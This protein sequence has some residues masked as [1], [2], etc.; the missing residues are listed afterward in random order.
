MDNV[1]FCAGYFGKRQG[2]DQV[3]N[4]PIVNFPRIVDLISVCIFL[5]SDNFSISEDARL[6]DRFSDLFLVDNLYDLI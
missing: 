4:V 6:A 1:L 2:M 5:S 3:F